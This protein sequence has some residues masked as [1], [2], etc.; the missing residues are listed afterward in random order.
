MSSILKRNPASYMGGG[1]RLTYSAYRKTSSI[2]LPNRKWD[3]ILTKEEEAVNHLDN[4]EYD[5]AALAFAIKEF[6]MDG[7]YLDKTLNK[8]QF[9]TLVR[10][11]LNVDQFHKLFASL[12]DETGD[13]IN[14][15]HAPA[16]ILTKFCCSSIPLIYATSGLLNYILSMETRAIIDCFAHT[17]DPTALFMIDKEF[18]ES[19][20]KDVL[21]KS[22]NNSVV[23]DNSLENMVLKNNPAFMLHDTWLFLV[24]GWT[25]E[26]V[27]E[28][29][30]SS[31]Y[32]ENINILNKS[33]DQVKMITAPEPLS[34]QQFST[35]SLGNL[36]LRKTAAGKLAGKVLS[37]KVEEE[38]GNWYR[39]WLLHFLCSQ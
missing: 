16:E 5:K 22:F 17:T 33:I 3:A 15:L 27:A 21:R 6:S 4:T 19:L 20:A 25:M 29:T 32:N 9:L 18:L 36:K 1:R 7:F 13:T 8:G 31:G 14:I 38:T 28:G 37:G 23:H 26:V 10:G 2:I 35:V 24:N 12:R 39:P 30:E 34:P 11:T